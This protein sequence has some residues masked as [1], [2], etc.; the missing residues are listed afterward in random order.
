MLS[1]NLEEYDLTNYDFLLKILKV[2]SASGYIVNENYY[3]KL[4]DLYEWAM[5]L[6]DQTKEHWNYAN[7]QVWK[8]FQK[9]DLW[10][11]FKTRIGRQR[12]GFSDNANCFI[13]YNC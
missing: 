10:Y 12:D 2:Q 1:Y 13:S 8:R 9:D 4:I 3:D 6:L 7:D 5:P 11:C